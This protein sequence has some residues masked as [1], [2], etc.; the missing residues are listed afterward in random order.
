MTTL[1]NDYNVTLMKND[2]N[3][4][5]DKITVNKKSILGNG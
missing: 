4:A 3:E 2:M 5:K 1:V